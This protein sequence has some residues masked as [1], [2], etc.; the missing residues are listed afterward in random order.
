MQ[1]PHVPRLL[2]LCTWFLAAN[3]T[4]CISASI[5]NTKEAVFELCSSLIARTAQ[6]KRE[7]DEDREDAEIEGGGSEGNS[8]EDFAVGEDIQ[9]CGSDNAVIRLA[10]FSVKEYLVS[11]KILKGPAKG[12]T[13]LGKEAHLL[14]VKSCLVYLL[15]FDNEGIFLEDFDTTFPLVS[16][17]AK[18]W[19]EHYH[20]ASNDDE[21]L[22]DL[23]SDPF[24][25][26]KEAYNNSLWLWMPGAWG[27]TYVGRRSDMIPAPI[28][29]ASFYGLTDIV[30]ALK[31]KG[32]D[33]NTIGDRLQTSL[34][35]AS[36]RGHERTVRLLPEHGAHINAI[37]EGPYGTA[38]ETA[39]A[40]SRE[41]IVRLLLA[42]NADVNAQSESI[43][44]TALVAASEHGNADIIQ[45]LL[46]YGADVNL[47][48][49]WIDTA[50]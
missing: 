28:Y 17:A 15:M 27:E 35:A 47:S 42:N 20:K 37:F 40:S 26:Q 24:L 46:A 1:F 6:A 23:T 29:Y 2:S 21:Q 33:L 4:R 49:K 50:L 3:G 19:A 38:L 30:A 39:S 7:G 5:S 25:R 13:V 18:Y 16:Y 44:I 32:A 34:I 41:E 31:E 9:K 8:E 11:N 45:I 48:T 12:Y 22:L 10:H 14:M 36:V 43:F